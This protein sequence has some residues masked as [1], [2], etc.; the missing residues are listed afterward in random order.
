MKN[1]DTYDIE[2]ICSNI[3]M[4]SFQHLIILPLILLDKQN[5]SGNIA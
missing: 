4:N 1:A 3:F 2:S 5:T